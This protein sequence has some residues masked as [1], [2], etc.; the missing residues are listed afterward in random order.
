L[1]R[2]NDQQRIEY[3]VFSLA[4]KFYFSEMKIMRII[5]IAIM[6]IGLALKIANVQGYTV[7]FVVGA[8]LM[9][10]PRFYQW[11]NTPR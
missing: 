1:Y 4:E 2:F 9:I 5:G 11:Y 3:A 6:F 7:A 10:I 8:A